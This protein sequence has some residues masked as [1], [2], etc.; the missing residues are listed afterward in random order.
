MINSNFRNKAP[1]I[2]P[3]GPGQYPVYTGVLLH[4][5][6]PA[7]YLPVL[8]VA[9]LDAKY[10]YPVVIKAGMAVAIDPWGYLIPATG[11]YA[12]GGVTMTYTATDISWGVIDLDNVTDA[13]LVNTEPTTW[14]T[15]QMAT[16][17]S[18]GA[19]SATVTGI[20][21]GIAHKDVFAHPQVVR[22]AGS[23][24]NFAREIPTCFLCGGQIELPIVM[25]AQSTIYAGSPLYAMNPTSNTFSAANV[26][27]M[28]RLGAFAVTDIGVTVNQAAVNVVKD[29]FVGKLKHVIGKCIEV[30]RIDDVLNLNEKISR[31]PGFGFSTAVT[32]ASTITDYANLQ[33]H[34]ITAIGLARNLGSSPT[35]TTGRWSMK[36][37]L[38]IGGFTS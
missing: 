15:T 25:S 27:N 31:A 16:V 20:T 36:V 22:R 8:E 11:Y 7:P 29:E 30:R 1:Q 28:G 17:A 32:A 38:T 26:L 5:C 18:A 3:L 9:K 10:D 21:V 19:S 6:Q 2:A 4:G 34:L 13:K 12:S 14:T 24:Y 33:P 37:N 23:D 35:S